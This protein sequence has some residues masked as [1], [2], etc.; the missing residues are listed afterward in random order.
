[1]PDIGHAAPPAFPP[2]STHD[3]SSTLLELLRQDS[4][5][6]NSGASFFPVSG[7][8]LTIP[9]LTVDPDKIIAI[10]YRLKPPKRGAH[11]GSASKAGPRRRRR[12]AHP[13]CSGRDPA[14]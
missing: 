9:R 3:W 13:Y 12:Q 5:L 7:A 10:V 8:S 1:M 11:G 6:L 14:P 4:V 2:W